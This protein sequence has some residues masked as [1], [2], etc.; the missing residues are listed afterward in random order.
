MKNP[1]GIGQS[2]PLAFFLFFFFAAFSCVFFTAGSDNAAR[3]SSDK[4]P[5]HAVHAALPI[6]TTEAS[7]TETAPAL[8]NAQYGA[9]VGLTDEI[10]ALVNQGIPSSL[11]KARDLIQERSLSNSDFGRSMYAVIV[12]MFRWLYPDVQARLQN[13]DPPQTAVYTKI[14]RGV[15]RGIYTPPSANG[16]YLEYILPFLALL[17]DASPA[18]LQ[19]A[20]PDLLKA[21]SL[22]PSG[23]PAP[24]FTAFVYEKT[25]R[26]QEAKQGYENT[27]ALSR[28]CYPAAL[29]L[30]R[31]LCNEKRYDDAERTLSDSL[32]LFPENAALKRSLA[33]LYYDKGDWVRAESALGALANPDTQ[34]RLLRAGALIELGRYSQANAQLDSY[35]S[36]GSAQNPDYLF[37]RARVQYEGFR[38]RDAALNYLR[39]LRATGATEEVSIYAARLLLE[40]TRPN[41]REEGRTLLQGLLTNGGSI[42]AA[43]LALEDA[44]RREAWAE[45]VPYMERLLKERRSTRDLINAHAVEQ[46]RGNAAAALSYA[47][48]LFRADPTNAQGALV[49]TAALID[50][51]RTSEAVSLIN[52]HLGTAAAGE[53]KSSYYY[54]RSRTRT[55]DEDRLNDL[56]SSLFEDPRNFQALTAMFEYYHRRKDRRALYYLKQALA[57]EP[58][59][60]RLRAYEKEY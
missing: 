20:L 9:S 60:E 17:K 12:Y 43:D 30:S 3:S 35:A 28:E 4:M 53:E 2:V 7:S 6:P 24:Y 59:N 16:D 50:A 58:N 18:R 32:M 44:V 46:G 27:L 26:V 11:L 45:A 36:G 37:L 31:I 33:V 47:A 14:L 39:T 54:L 48:E 5:L 29:G 1:A 56:R 52:T 25:G 41:E 40:S 19:S 13:A 23:I 15:D 57:I 51:G 34:T 38:N 42:E 55:G 10:R 8:N 22:N 49:Y 21:V